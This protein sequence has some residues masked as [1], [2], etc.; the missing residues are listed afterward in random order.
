[1]SKTWG[2]WNYSTR[3]LKRQTTLCGCFGMNGTYPS[4]KGTRE[5][6]PGLGRDMFSVSYYCV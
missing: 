6:A 3:N 4:G 2:I 1:M 5:N